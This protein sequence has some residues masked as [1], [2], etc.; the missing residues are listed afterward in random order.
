LQAARR[1][2]AGRV[3][4]IEVVW[5][6]YLNSTASLSADAAVEVE[7]G[8]DDIEREL[9]GETRTLMGREQRWGFARRDGGV[10]QELLEV[11]TPYVER[12][13][14]S[15]VMLVVGGSSHRYHHVMG[16]VPASL[17]RHAKVPVLVV[18]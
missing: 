16:S 17:V 5:V 1:L 6:A 15:E 3:G 7:R 8:F 2:L 13:D 11:A 18:P 12:H 10:P 14:G 4:R 9:S